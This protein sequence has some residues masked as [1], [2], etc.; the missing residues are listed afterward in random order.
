MLTAAMLVV[1]N[2]SPLSNLAIIGRLDLVRE[3]LHR[4]IIPPAVRSELERNPNPQAQESLHVAFSEGWINVAPLV[5]RVRP[6][7]LL[8]LDLGE[9]EALTLASERKAS[10]LLLDESEAR[11]KAA[12]LGI[13]HTGALGILRQARKS[14]RIPSLKSEILRLRSEAHFFI[15]PMLEKTLLISVGEA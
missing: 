4:V 2:T 6:E 12:Q 14:E 8:K 3:Q 10:L 15:S 7:L 9:A 5:E 13:A 11:L 1:S